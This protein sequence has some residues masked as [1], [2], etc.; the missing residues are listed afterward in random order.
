[1]S[2]KKSFSKNVL[3]SEHVCHSCI[4]TLTYL[5][6]KTKS[7]KGKA[8]MGRIAQLYSKIR[9]RNT[10]QYSAELNLALLVETVQR[11]GVRTIET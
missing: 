10:V 3:Y 4:E 5:L 6:N 9:R 7:S 2:T 8:I 11:Q 1:M